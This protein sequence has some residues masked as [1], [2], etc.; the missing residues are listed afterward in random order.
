MNFILI[1]FLL[2]ILLITIILNKSFK[3][4]MQA[5]P[6]ELWKTAIQSLYAVLD[7]FWKGTSFEKTQPASLCGK[8]QYSD[9]GSMEARETLSLLP[10]ANASS[11]VFEMRIP[12]SPFKD[13]IIAYLYPNPPNSY[14]KGLLSF[15]K[16]CFSFLIKVKFH[17][18]S[19]LRNSDLSPS[20]P[21]S[22]FS[23]SSLHQNKLTL[24]EPDK[25]QMQRIQRPF[26]SKY[27]LKLISV[28]KASR[29]IHH[30]IRCI[31]KT[32]LKSRGSRP[33]KP[34]REVLGN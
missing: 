31:N 12:P 27:L 28:R 9:I 19:S 22:S 20:S 34:I 3:D 4:S 21:N 29:I 7:S 33:L 25:G 18:V 16:I 23:S 14:V 26:E 17:L 1:L 24:T 15:T 2:K 13:S 30:K 10:I 32:I 6:V 11:S 8:H 5:G